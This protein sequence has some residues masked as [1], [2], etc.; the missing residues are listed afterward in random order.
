M[1]RV[2]SYHDSELRGCF[3]SRC[4]WRDKLG[5]NLVAIRLKRAARK[6]LTTSSS[7]PRPQL[8]LAQNYTSPLE[9][10][11]IQQLG[12]CKMKIGRSKVACKLLAASAICLWVVL[13]AGAQVQ[14]TTTSTTGQPT[15]EVKVERGEVL[16]VEGNDLV[17][18]ME[19]GTIRHIP[20]VPESARVR[21]DG[22]ELGIHDLK[23]G[24]KLERTITTTTTPRTITTVQ[25][26]QGKVW[27]ATR[28]SVIL[29]LDDGTN[30]KFNIPAGQ[31]FDVNGEMV[32]AAHLKK[33]TKISATK[34][35]E[36]PETEISEERKVTGTM[37]PPPPPADRPI[38]IVVVS[39][40]KAPEQPP[41]QPAQAA[42]A[43]PPKLPQTA[44]PLPLIAL[45]GVL[46]CGS[47]FGIRMLRR[48]H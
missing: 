21:V 38:L 4:S 18:K 1:T 23:P 35:V 10:E 7:T 32:D 44:S 17:V 6:S 8:N 12:A 46:L 14:T 42:E 39:P 29:T 20:N 3:P 37:P 48:R 11:L 40:E 43:A 25:S 9:R 13:S 28:N 34:V 24:M 5:S 16:L 41:A 47:S 22:K 31:K 30:Q 26:V 33:G 2:R 45:M 27:S 19:D 36:V 15:K